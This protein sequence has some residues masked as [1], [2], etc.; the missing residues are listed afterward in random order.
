MR[1]MRDRFAND[2][3]RNNDVFFNSDVFVCRL[4]SW[5]VLRPQRPA[6]GAVFLLPN[7]AA[8]PSPGQTGL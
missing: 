8:G 6:A 2:Q 7:A 3:G 1:V 4:K 5:S